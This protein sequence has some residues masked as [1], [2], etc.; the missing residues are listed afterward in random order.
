M[1]T[2]DQQSQHHLEKLTVLKVRNPPLNKKTHPLRMI[3][4]KITW[5]YHIMSYL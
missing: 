1:K 3:N 5:E 4:H 2:R